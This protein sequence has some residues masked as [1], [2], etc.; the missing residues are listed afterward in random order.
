[1]A[2]VLMLHRSFGP[3]VGHT[4]E[5]NHIPRTLGCEEDRSDCIHHYQAMHSRCMFSHLS[6]AL[7]LQDRYTGDHLMS[8]HSR[9]YIQMH[10]LGKE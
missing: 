8:E 3:I 5:S 7:S 9:G 10:C 4:Q 2:V 6:Q 1:M